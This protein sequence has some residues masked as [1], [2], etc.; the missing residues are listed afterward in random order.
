MSSSSRRSNVRRS[1]VTA[2][3]RC[4]SRKQRCD[5]NIPACSACERAG[6]TCVSIDVDGRLVPRSYIRSLED[7]VAHLERCLIAHGV[8]DYDQEAANGRAT[9]STRLSPAT[10]ADSSSPRAVQPSASRLSDTR[11]D[12]AKRL[13]QRTLLA[14]LR[15]TVS[16]CVK[17]ST[18]SEAVT[19]AVT[20]GCSPYELLAGQLPPTEPAPAPAKDVA[21]KLCNAYFTHCDFFSP[22]LCRQEICEILDVFYDNI[23]LQRPQDAPAEFKIYMVFATAVC[24][25]NRADPS[26]SPSKSE[27]FFASAVQV[28]STN[29]D[30]VCERGLE[31]LEALLLTIQYLSFAAN[32]DTAWLFVGIATRMVVHL[33]L[34][35]DH[36]RISVDR[37]DTHTRQRLFWATYTFERNLC[38]VL[39]RP[40]SIPDEAIETPLPI[41]LPN[42][43][44]SKSLGPLAIHLIRFRQLESE[45][46][47]TLHQKSPSNGAILDYETW[48]V[49]MH[50]RL[51]QW[52][53]DTPP[54]DGESPLA[55]A[56]V[57]EA[58]LVTS[59]VQLY[60]PSRHLSNPSNSALRILAQ[61]AVL[62]VDMYK[63]EFKN[64]SL[65]FYWRTIRNLF[66]AGVALVYC[67]RTASSPC[68]EFDISDLAIAPSI[69]QCSAVLWGMVERF[70]GGKAY[71]DAFDDLVE[72]QMP[73]RQGATPWDPIDT[74]WLNAWVVN[75]NLP[76]MTDNFI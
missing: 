57:F 31:Q 12:L 48:Q 66:R 7:R 35:T 6:V 76:P 43:A 47:T 52:R 62:A 2:C 14:H 23:A 69:Q 5:Q 34:H 17:V 37:Q 75:T 44:P 61:N 11:D 60:Y 20:G 54:Y 49:Y 65:R 9:I 38:S 16:T 19:D 29:Y 68:A 55:P 26:L 50:Q 64:G 36:S 67:A 8:H 72:H 4:K 39:E 18:G 71:R 24:L 27:A 51:L 25:L 13:V 3:S 56:S 15:H 32:L 53:K 42:V 41:Y 59:L 21:V 33:G 22:I 1:N 28:L 10:T 73:T 74:D 46:Y 45:I 63:T 30:L 58:F 40:F 70:H